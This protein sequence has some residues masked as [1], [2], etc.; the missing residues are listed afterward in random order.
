MV[1]IKEIYPWFVLGAQ[2][3]LFINMD[4]IEMKIALGLFVL[5]QV[6]KQMRKD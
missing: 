2:L 5:F 1:S 3:L 4:S 6:W